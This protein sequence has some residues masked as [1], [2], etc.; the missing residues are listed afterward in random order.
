M[1]SLPALSGHNTKQKQEEGALGTLDT[2]YHIHVE[3]WQVITKFGHEP[4]TDKRCLN[5]CNSWEACQSIFSTEALG[6]KSG[7]AEGTEEV[8]FIK[9]AMETG[10]LGLIQKL[11]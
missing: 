6:V 8:V 3:Q 9:V 5:I 11:G 1:C 7:I 4:A 2:L 10:S